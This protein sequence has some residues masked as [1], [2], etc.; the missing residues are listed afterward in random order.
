MRQYYW[1][2]RKCGV[3]E[4][5]TEDSH[6]ARSKADDHDHAEH[7]SKPVSSFGFKEEP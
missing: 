6:T 1:A 3:K 7:N 4:Q 2:C 5:N